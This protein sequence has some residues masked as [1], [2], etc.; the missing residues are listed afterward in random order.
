MFFFRQIGITNCILTAARCQP[1]RWSNGNEAAG[2]ARC[3]SNGK[4][5]SAG[6]KRHFD[7]YRTSKAP[8]LVSRLL[9]AEKRKC[10][11]LKTL[12]RWWIENPNGNKK[13]KPTRTPLPNRSF[14]TGWATP[15]N[16]REFYLLC[17][18]TGNARNF[19]CHAFLSMTKEAMKVLLITQNLFP[20]R[21]QDANRQ[22]Q[23]MISA[24]SKLTARCFSQV[25]A[26][27]NEAY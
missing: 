27:S 26:F 14:K 18:L 4:P 24:S 3:G 2:R 5:T 17:V 13:W 21:H 12:C 6:N 25:E 19:A 11:E 9:V 10:Q 7:G 8:L 16:L 20:C 23:E 22:K 1:A 15:L